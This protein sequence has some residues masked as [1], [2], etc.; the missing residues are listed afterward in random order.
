MVPTPTPEPNVPVEETPNH[1]V[2]PGN[3]IEETPVN[4][5]PGP[6]VPNNPTEDNKPNA[7]VEDSKP[8]LPVNE[9]KSSVI[10]EG[11]TPPTSD[12]LSICSNTIR[13]CYV[14]CRYLCIKEEGKRIG[15]P[16][17]GL[18]LAGRFIYLRVYLY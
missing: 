17:L 10:Q 1:P 8:N 13:Q 3:P 5:T 2:N 11:G 7:P 18:G 16:F 6:E 4:P 15:F 12:G 9:T 14:K